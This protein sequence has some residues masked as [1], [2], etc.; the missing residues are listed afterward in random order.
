MSVEELAEKVGEMA[1][2]RKLLKRASGATLG[3]LGLA[4][5]L[6]GRAMAY[7]EAHGC[8]LCNPPA[9]DCG[10]PWVECGWC[11]QGSCHGSPSHWHY[12]CECYRS[13]SCD[14]SCPATCSALVG[15]HAC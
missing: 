4:G 3:L 5:F 12:C 8:S 10:G 6:P 9:T 2:R 14:G 15:T 1:D 11:W 13:P 7:G